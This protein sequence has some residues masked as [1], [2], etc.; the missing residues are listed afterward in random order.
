MAQRHPRHRTAFRHPRMGPHNGRAWR[1]DFRG[2]RPRCRSEDRRSYPG[3]APRRGAKL[4]SP[5]PA[6]RSRQR[7][8]R[9]VTPATVRRFAIPE[10]AHT[11]GEHG[12]GTFAAF[13]RDAGLKTGA[14][15][16]AS[17]PA[18][19]R[20]SR[21]HSP[22]GA[23]GNED[24]ATSPSPPYG[25]SPSPNGSTQRASMA[26]GVSRPPAAMLASSPGGGLKTGAPIPAAYRGA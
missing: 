3:I 24:G 14:P 11:T 17:L 12:G 10:W 6:W 21:R 7:G 18:G 23:A 9:N 15:I 1:W 19:E 16:P 5:L 13:G 26:V 25:V 2:L 22:H 20:N 8:R 4:P